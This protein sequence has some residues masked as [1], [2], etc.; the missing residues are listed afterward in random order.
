MNRIRAI[1]NP[2]ASGGRGRRAASRLF[3]ALNAQGIAVEPRFTEAP[4]HGSHLAR[5]AIADRIDRLIV[6]GGDGSIHEVAQGLVGVEAGP[7]PPLLL[8]PVGTGNDFFRM[9]DR[10]SGIQGVVA[11]LLT[12]R[13]ERFDVGRVR[14]EGGERIFVNLLGTGIDVDILNCRSRFRRF[15]GLL[16]YLAALVSAMISFRPQA[17]AIEIDADSDE[18]WSVQGP[19]MIAVITVG[20]S[21]GGGFR[22]N[23][24]A[25]ATDGRLDLCHV[26]S[27]GWIRFLDLVP[28]VIRGRHGDSSP[29]S[30]GR[31]QR[32]IVRRPHGDP[33]HFEVDGEIVPD[34][35]RE[36]RVEVVPAALPVMVPNLGGE[37]R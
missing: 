3:S 17:L 13:V 11:T 9:I 32:A 19:T 24:Q 34:P 29:V 7:I 33:F 26:G 22:I 31:L 2:A 25:S 15:P 28:K 8:Y 5:A 27:L 4:G 18:G 36:L 30:T 23:P 21:I 16:Q 1:V 35:V 20:P 10:S 37:G 6:V 14:W 12:G